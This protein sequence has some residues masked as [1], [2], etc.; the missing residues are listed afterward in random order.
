MKT[1]CVLVLVFMSISL[2]L[3][4]NQHKG[5]C[6]SVSTIMSVSVCDWSNDR[7]ALDLDCVGCVR[8]AG[9]VTRVGERR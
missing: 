3:S 9:G 6:V 8:D 2:C 1:F 7:Y 4:V 5:L